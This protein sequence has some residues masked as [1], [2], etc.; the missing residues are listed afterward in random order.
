MVDE[1]KW[2]RWFI[3]FT[4]G[5]LFYGCAHRR[6][7][8]REPYHLVYQTEDSADEAPQRW[9]P[10]FVVYGHSQAYN[11]IGRPKVVLDNEGRERVFIDPDDPVVYFL[12]RTFKTEKAVYT[13]HIYRIHFSQIPFS[14]IPFNLSSG[15]NVG[16]MVVVTLNA[17]NLPVL[18]TTVHTCGCYKAIVPTQYLPPD[19]FPEGWSGERMRVYGEH[20]PTLL[21]FNSIQSPEIMVHLRPGVH[22]VMDI[23]V[24]EARDLYSPPFKIATM[25]MESLDQLNHLPVNGGTTSFYHSDGVLKGHVKGSVKPL[26]T[27]FLSLISLDLFVGTDKAYGDADE[28]G[29]PFYTSLKP[30]R[31]KDSDMWDFAGFLWYWGW[32]L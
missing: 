23:D 19:A 11:R 5:I 17:Q 31:R 26:E 25:K 15:K 2:V 30:W 3:V 1:K 16:L 14:L 24:R 27:L 20:L 6:P 32:R 9:A 29:N 10:A 18:V 12:R 4:A 8:P 28:T 7:L 21:K 13:N 22:R